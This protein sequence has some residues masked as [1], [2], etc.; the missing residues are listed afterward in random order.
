[1]L[2]ASV[3]ENWCKHRWIKDVRMV[4]MQN[5]CNKLYFLDQER[6]NIAA[7]TIIQSWKYSQHFII[8][9]WIHEYATF[10]WRPDK[11]FA[12]ESKVLCTGLKKKSLNAAANISPRGDL[13]SKLISSRF[14]SWWAPSMCL[15]KLRQ[16]FCGP[17]RTSFENGGGVVVSFCLSQNVCNKISVFLFKCV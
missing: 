17:L 12:D 15:F 6:F 4:W 5:A 10:A 14:A 2:F 7:F 16:S 11:V 1:M 8:I 13:P 3:W 9:C